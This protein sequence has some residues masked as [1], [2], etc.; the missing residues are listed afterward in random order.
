MQHEHGDSR[1]KK[2]EKEGVLLT[3]LKCDEIMSPFS[4]EAELP[5]KH[6]GPPVFSWD[7]LGKKEKEKWQY[8]SN[9][10]YSGDSTEQK[11]DGE[12]RGFH[13]YLY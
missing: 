7:V 8:S 2:R 13:I 10:I 12:S 5:K 1:N 4:K 3:R 11:D 6:T 9:V